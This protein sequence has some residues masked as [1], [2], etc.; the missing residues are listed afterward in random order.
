MDLHIPQNITVQLGNTVQ[1][2]QVNDARS[3]RRSSNAST[4]FRFVEEVQSDVGDTQKSFRITIKSLTLG[5]LLFSS[6]VCGTGA[7]IMT[8]TI[9]TASVNDM[10]AAHQSGL[11]RELLA[12]QEGTIAQTR[13]L[14]INQRE[15]LKAAIENSFKFAMIEND[16]KISSAYN[17]IRELNNSVDWI[18]KQKNKL[19]SMLEA[20]G[21]QFVFVG[22]AAVEVTF[23]IR[24][25][26]ETTYE[27]HEWEGNQ[28]TKSKL[29]KSGEVTMSTTTNG[30]QT[31][32]PF[33]KVS[34]AIPFGKQRCI[35]ER[36]TGDVMRTMTLIGHIGNPLDGYQLSSVISFSLSYM[37]K[38][39]HDMTIWSS[40]AR[41]F[42]IIES[43]WLIVRQT[44]RK[45]YLLA[46]SHGNDNLIPA[47]NASDPSIRNI[48][49]YASSDFSHIKDFAIIGEGDSLSYV[50]ATPL[51]IYDDQ[52]DWIGIDWYLVLSTSYSF[53]AGTDLVVRQEIL[54]S[55]ESESVEI[56]DQYTTASLVFALVT[57]IVWSA[58]SLLVGWR[59]AFT[60]II[61]P[62]QE[63]QCAISEIS[64][65][66]LDA[67]EIKEEKNFSRTSEI[68]NMES[69]F[70]CMM[71]KLCEYRCFVPRSLLAE[72]GVIGGAAAVAP[73]GVVSV[74]FTD[75]FESSRLWVESQQGM[76][77][78][79][80]IHNHVLRTA[81]HRHSG[82][83]V[84]TV[85]DSFMVS[86]AKVTDAATFA[87]AVQELLVKQQW[88]PSLGLSAVKENNTILWNGLRIR[89]GAHCGDVI[90]EE[91]PLTGRVDY[92][93]VTVAKA[94]R[95]LARAKPG[96][97]CITSEFLEMIKPSLAKLREPEIS[98]FGDFE[99]KGLD[100]KHSL[101]LMVPK[102]MGLRITAEVGK[103]S[104]IKQ[105][106]TSSSPTS[107]AG[108]DL[109][110]S[111][112]SVVITTAVTNFNLNAD[113]DEF[114]KYSLIV[115]AVLDGAAQSDGTHSST[116]GEET[117]VV[118]NSKGGRHIL[119]SLR[120]VIY[121]FKKCPDALM[122]LATGSVLQGNVGTNIQ[123]YKMTSG[124][125]TIIGSCLATY[126]KSIGAHALVAD[127]TAFK[128][129]KTNET[130]RDLTRPIDKWIWEC[131]KIDVYE[132]CVPLVQIAVEG[133][134]GN[135][136]PLTQLADV[137][138]YRSAYAKAEESAD[139]SALVALSKRFPGDEVLE[140][141]S[142][143][144]ESQFC[145][146]PV[147][148]MAGFSKNAEDEIVYNRI[149]K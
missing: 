92:K 144:Q 120:F 123:R 139:K 14:L 68:R 51:R 71:I 111:L 134:L 69:A 102:G 67:T 43:E 147:L 110:L 58:I 54:S 100:G 109:G 40:D 95:C 131:Y 143:R 52:N 118:W 35:I 145:R 29:S 114:D 16:R 74:V 49:I 86:F 33:R 11:N 56:T 117:V 59:M 73:S 77:D 45:G 124:K 84:K 70:G 38:L 4:G 46:T 132:L 17:D 21:E 10:K 126:A 9:S 87:I 88:P 6:A 108:V 96:T 1:E 25:T 57:I 98:Y 93:G 115:R 61:R 41:A 15:S 34:S 121:L 122:G 136:L 106:T 47:V 94:A 63:L 65:S 50:I 85:G 23:L 104:T 39:L 76:N 78:A 89:M 19:L 64:Y 81:L 133:N 79:T 27:L 107:R 138:S 26:N 44:S 101:H 146:R 83:E 142:L 91:N 75:I 90:T 20:L 3:R 24:R 80:D 113:E 130:L 127:C 5:V 99:L 135:S 119:N 60:A 140:H 116:L 55:F 141:I 48:S 13:L 32:E 125:P 112:N 28:T 72:S 97:I 18:R 148:M 36:G 105:V 7:A 82:Y 2:F 8:Q 149:K 66:N 103:R 31:L 30:V 62:L 22:Y 128:T 53:A 129:L 12:S 37:N 137:D 42:I